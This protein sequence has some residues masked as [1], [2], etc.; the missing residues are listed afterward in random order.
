MGAA[1][2]AGGIFGMIAVDHHG[3]GG[4]SVI[5]HKTIPFQPWLPVRAVGT[6]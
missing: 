6:A 3:G 1:Q 5:A 4:V 2:G